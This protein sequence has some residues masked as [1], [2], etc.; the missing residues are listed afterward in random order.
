MHNVKAKNMQAVRNQLNALREE[1]HAAQRDS[2]R[3]SDELEEVEAAVQ[4]LGRDRDRHKRNLQE[5]HSA[6]SKAKRD[7]DFQQR[8]AGNADAR[9]GNEL[10][11]LMSLIDQ[12]ERKFSVKPIGP[13]GKFVTM[14]DARWTDA[15]EHAIG[16]VPLR[17]VLVQNYQD[18]QLCFQLVKQNGINPRQVYIHRMK[19]D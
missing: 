13:V 15:V 18:E 8:N 3:L 10:M 14:K 4:S 7:F 2:K 9:F 19:I 1:N 16:Q 12:N 5:L 11:K 6:V 17:T